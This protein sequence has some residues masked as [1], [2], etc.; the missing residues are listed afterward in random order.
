MT[1]RYQ[2][3]DRGFSI[4]G[5]QL[6][7]NRALYGGHAHDDG[8]NRF[9]TYAG[10]VPIFMGASSDYTRDTWCYQA[11]NGVLLSGVA[12]T[13]GVREGGRHDNYSRW[14]HHCTD[15]TAEWCH[16]WMEYEFSRVSGYF[17]H[18]TG[19]IAVYP[20]EPDDGFLVHYELTADQQ[21]IFCAG[22]GG[23]TPPFGNF[24]HHDALRREFSV[25]DCADNEAFL[26][27]NGAGISGPEGVTMRIG[28]D[29][30]CVFSL[31]GASAMTEDCPSFFLR[32]H[33][34][35][36][37]IVKLRRQLSAGERF[38]GNLAVTRNP[39][40]ECAPADYL[41]DPEIEKRL[42]GNIRRRLAGISFHT[43][44][45]L[46]DHSVTDSVLA[47]DASFHGRSI[48]HGVIGY[49][50]PFL[51]W[52]N[53]YA[54]SLLGWH[55]RVR[56]SIRSHVAT[57]TKSDKPEKV[58]YD[59][60][61]R[62]DLDHE[63]TQYHHLENS[64]GHLPAMLDKDDIY[65]MQEVGVDMA[66]H[67]LQCSNDLELGAEIYDSLCAMLDWEE[68]IFDPD[69]DGLYQN[70]LNTWISDGHSYNGAGCAQSSAYNYR[71]NVDTA[72]LGR[73][74]G[75]DVSK[76]EIRAAKIREAIDRMLWL[77]DPGVLAESIDTVGN[78]LVHP[79][80]E[81]S[82]AYLAIDCGT[83]DPKRAYRMLAWI[84]RNIRSVTTVG[85]GG[86]L[87]YSSNWM[88]KKYSTCGLFPAENAAL[89]LAF[90]QV[91][92]A[93]P[94]WEIV[95]G[96]ADAFA[97]SNHPGSLSHVL[98]GRG[99]NDDGDVDLTDVSSCYLRLLIEGM[100]GVKFRRLDGEVE[101][102]PQL[103]PEWKQ[104]E[105]RLPELSLAL[106][107]DGLLDTLRADV[108]IPGRKLI[109][110]PL[111]YAE[112]EQ[113]FLNGREIVGTLSDGFGCPILNV[114][115]EETGE[116]E[117]AVHYVDRP[118]PRFKQD[119]ITVLPGGRAVVEM[120]TGAVE[121]TEAPSGI[122]AEIV[123]GGKCAIMDMPEAGTD[124]RTVFFHVGHTILPLEAR[125]LRLEEPE[126]PL[127]FEK[128]TAVDLSGCFNSSLS[129]IHRQEFRS[130][131]PAGYSIGVRLNGRYAWEWNSFGHNALNV[132]DSLLRNCGGTIVTNS[133]LRFS[134]PGTGNN[135]LSVSIWENFPTEAALPL[136]GRASA[137]AVLLCGTTN[138]MQSHVVNGKLSVIYGDGGEV[139]VELI[140]P[141]NFDDFLIPSYQQ[142]N[143]VVEFGAGT[144][145][146]VQIIRL[147]PRRP[148]RELRV[149]AVANEVILNI[150]GVTLLS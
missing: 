10:D 123:C 43:P 22:L 134:T 58:W 26:A 91:G 49:H 142:K 30:E 97:L 143:E 77:E 110:L 19:R 69:G 83:V 36:A 70:F 106:R 137:I 112:V 125:T 12:M 76:L 99:G 114:V 48:Y 46:L 116:L 80:P 35:G 98:S 86:K 101:L 9:F 93:G 11:K 147:D 2:C 129:G 126:E 138:A 64:S 14:F 29:F 130:P 109:R 95:N 18:F 51:G 33:D 39:E 24:I 88:P 96:L 139:P 113:L 103:P 81:L 118:L 84:R 73:L 89:A 56:R 31:D 128:Q 59:G 82:T 44:D 23:I 6:S 32:P 13:E 8:E 45:R 5:S 150:L 149:E 1:T 145:G 65:N 20:L 104:S 4:F 63:G 100:W 71:A 21:C 42:R 72:K 79:S 102:F 50:T 55:D 25:E 133:G 108:R 105:L 140:Q 141:D 38:V 92:D 34:G 132:D 78:R 41:G 66:L 127:K 16:G 7:F 115:T 120:E 74:L 3:T 27:E 52:R 144:H 131:R 67:Y 90:F 117:L 37:R 119:S 136:S 57:M 135:A 28:A 54:S 124:A 122:T 111:R 17:P 146:L 75:K 40:N 47:N 61:D 148:L 53:W 107:R 60:A 94:A 85:R 68:R 121:S 15:V 62:P 87:Y